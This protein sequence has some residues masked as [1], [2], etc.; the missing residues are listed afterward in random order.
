MAMRVRRM[1]L[2]A[3]V[4]AGASFASCGSEEPS[5]AR[6]ERTCGHAHVSSFSG[7]AEGP[8][9]CCRTSGSV[10]ADCGFVISRTYHEDD[11]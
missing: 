6:T 8:S 9:G 1:V 4:L 7:V 2:A 3:L 11:K 5:A 10:C